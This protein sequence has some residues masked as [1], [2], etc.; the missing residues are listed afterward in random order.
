M[1][2]A[3]AESEAVYR[4]EGEQVISRFHAGGPWDDTMQHGSAPAAL[5]AWAAEN[6]PTAVPMQI[7]RLTIDLMR[8][9]PVAPLTLMRRVVREG[10]KIQLCE[11][12]LCA[13]GV[14]VVR[15][16]VLKVLTQPDLIPG[17]AGIPA[18]QMPGPEMCPAPTQLA[19][20]ESPFV[21][22]IS[23]RLA[24]G[25]FDQPGL[26]AIWY[27]ADRPIVDGFPASPAMRAA[28]TA[29]FCN[30]TG[31]VLD[32]DGWLFPN[33]DL[34]VST[35]RPARGEWILVEAETM[36]GP[37]GMGIACGRLADIHG[38]FGRATQTLVLTRR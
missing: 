33:G 16:T 24:K 17:G 8:P 36:I 31:S 7:A 35:I 15:G 38:Y 25:G 4:V 6:L 19:G 22:G 28:L 14:E 5:V 3:S 30:G 1:T 27:R 13:D 10:R 20:M 26:A 34:T 11:I 23:M 21:D 18:F 29:D 32:I 2:A 37:D 12:G 9:V